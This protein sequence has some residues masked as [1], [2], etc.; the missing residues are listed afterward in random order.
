MEAQR[1]IS[2]LSNSEIGTKH[3]Y[4][5]LLAKCIHIGEYMKSKELTPEQRENWGNQLMECGRELLDNY[6]A[7]QDSERMI[8]FRPSQFLSGT[9][10]RRN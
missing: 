6:E 10:P 9:F 8:S 3:W 4:N 7:V 2:Q 1:N 5:T